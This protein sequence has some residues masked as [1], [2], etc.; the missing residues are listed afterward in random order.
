LNRVLPG[1]LYALSNSS[2]AT[3]NSPYLAPGAGL[4]IVADVEVTGK[5][6][7]YFG[8]LRTMKWMRNAT[9]TPAKT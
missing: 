4:T 8:E 2:I 1:F 6:Q 9:T 7:L 3:A 5:I